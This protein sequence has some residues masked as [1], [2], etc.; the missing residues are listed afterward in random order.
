M[1]ICVLILMYD[2]IKFQ[3]Q[4]SDNSFRVKKNQY[5]FANSG[6]YNQVHFVKAIFQIHSKQF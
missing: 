3:D 1:L 5:M 6:Q 4:D 2:Y